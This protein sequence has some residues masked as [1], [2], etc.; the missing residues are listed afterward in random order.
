MTIKEI[1]KNILFYATV[2]KCV[3]CKE[4][5]DINDAPLCK[6]CLKD[7]EWRKSLLCTACAKPFKECTCAP[8][9]LQN[10]YV[11]RLVK[12][13]RYRSSFD[14]ELKVP[15]NEL[16]YNVKRYDRVDLIEFIAQE[17]S[18]SIVKSIPDYHKFSVTNVPRSRR[19]IIKYGHD[20]SAKIAKAVARRLGIEYVSVLKSLQKKAQK[21]LSR[22]RE[23]LTN[24]KYD[25]KRSANL[26]SEKVF[27]VDDIVTSGASMG[28]AA[29]LLRGLGAKTIV[30]V[31]MG[32]AYRDER[33]YK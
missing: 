3:C 24:A 29:M 20:H 16:I 10:H 22:K 33:T 12:L 2:P 25:Y 32:I 18:E 14:E 8:V 4:K 21:K 6:R 26:T 23:R 5:L 28:H 31:T 11:K 7:H 19:R 9:Y 15:S 1:W 13:F 17:L 30:G 27:L